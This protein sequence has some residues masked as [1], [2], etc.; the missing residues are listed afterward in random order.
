MKISTYIKRIIAVALPC[1]FILAS[2]SQES[3]SE[4]VPTISFRENPV[5]YEAGNQ[6]LTVSASSSWSIILSDSNWASVSPS[7]GTSSNGDVR[8][9]Y[10]A[11][12]STS[13]RSITITVKAGSK[14]KQY[15]FTQNGKTSGGSTSTEDP[16][17]PDDPENNTVVTTEDNDVASYSARLYGSFSDASAAPRE[18]GFEWGTSPYELG[19]VAQSED[20]FTTTSGSFSADIENLSDGVT[21][22]YRAYI[23]VWENGEG[24]YYYGSVNSFTT[25]KESTATSSSY[26]GWFE[27]PA[28]NV[29]KSGNYLV[30]GDDATEY[31]AFHLCAGGET[32]PNGETARNYTV[33]YSAE[34]HCPVWVA[35]PRHSM[36][37]GSASRTNSYTTDDNIPSDIQYYSKKTGGGCNKGHMLGSA[38]RTSSTA[39]NRQ[40]FYYTNIAPQLSSGFNTGGGGWNTLE[41]WVDGQVCADTL[42]EVVGAY[43]ERFTDGYGNTVSPSTISFGGRSDVDMPTMYY[44]VLLRTKKGN[45][46]KAVNK[47][48]ASELK[49]AAFVRSHTNN[50]KG[51]SVT[52]K[53]MMSV[54]DLEKITGVTYFPNVPNAPKSSF[55]ASDWGL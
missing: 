43:F 42:Y 41:D 21:Y 32:S 44:Y 39:T 52:S 30:N 48:S 38:E 18:V 46:G 55:T 19:N 15:T 2:C 22:Y 45:S 34:H 3:S 51:Q 23:V 4:S 8:L 12:S 36:Y 28:M 24:V 5:S 11:N 31:F 17:D 35:A 20:I 37:V 29:S 1:L 54:A 53:E 49:C 26:Y 27:L 13:S 40:V 16:D 25:N 50:L 7:S 6:H 33:C 14:S 10:E 9:F 47:C